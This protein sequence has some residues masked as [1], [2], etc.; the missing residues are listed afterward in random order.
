MSDEIESPSVQ[1][2]Q[3]AASPQG[4]ISVEQDGDATTASAADELGGA[5]E[6]TD[7]R[8]R[9][10][11]GRQLAKEREKTS[12]LEARIAAMEAR[13]LAAQQ[14]AQ[15]PQQQLDIPEYITTP[16]DLEK[17]MAAKTAIQTQVKAQYEQVYRAVVG[18]LKQEGGELHEEIFKEM[19]QNYNVIRTGDP[20]HDAETNYAKAQAAVLRRMAS[21]SSP[22][23]GEKAKGT[24]PNVVAPSSAKNVSTSNLS[25]EV[26]AFIKQHGMSAETV[27]R[28][29]TE[30]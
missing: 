9:S 15:H 18:G 7:N 16:A 6:P 10:K 13:F 28:V 1:D 19:M 29:F 11:L 8:E 25:P 26:Q 22:L 12:A 20:R 23:R 3:D 30:K 14:Q 4:E 24:A 27:R 21:G 5:E 2:A 17:Y